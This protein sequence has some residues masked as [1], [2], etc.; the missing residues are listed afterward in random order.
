MKI[1]T[2]LLLLISSSIYA[3]TGA[4]D[5]CYANL[6]NGYQDSAL[7]I[8]HSSYV[9][10]NTAEMLDEQMAYNA[11]AKTLKEQDCQI[12][13]SLADIK[14]TVAL[15][16]ILCRADLRVGYFL[17]LKDYVDTVNLIFNRWD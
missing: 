14:C 1:L 12:E 7:F 17:I 9:Y 13:L 5:Q 8:Q 11:L 4:S 6:T 2:I 3:Q 10:S 16:T 15:N